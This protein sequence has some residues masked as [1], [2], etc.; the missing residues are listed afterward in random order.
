MAAVAKAKPIGQTTNRMVMGT[1]A[2]MMISHHAPDLWRYKVVMRHRIGAIR[3]QKGP[4][5]AGCKARSIAT[6]T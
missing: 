5:Q 1:P 6:G 4:G 2:A 3:R